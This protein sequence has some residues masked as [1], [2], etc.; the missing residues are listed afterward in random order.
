MNNLIMIAEIKNI[1]LQK[2]I[3]SPETEILKIML[4]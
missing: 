2:E 4:G 3:S 1:F